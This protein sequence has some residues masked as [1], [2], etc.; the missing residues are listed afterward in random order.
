MKRALL[1]GIDHYTNFNDLAGC[2]NDV[3]A[4]AP[5]LSRSEDNSA[6]F[7]CQLRTTSL[8]GVTRDALLG[9][10]DALL[11]GGADLA[12]A[13]FAGHGSGSDTDVTLATEDGTTATPGIPLSEIMTKISVSPVKEIVLVLDCCFA[14]A[15]GGVPQLNVSAASLRGGVSI[16]AASRGDQ[17]AAETAA[18]R[19]LFSTYLSGA[20][21]GGAAD[22]LGRITVAGLYAYLDESFGAWDQRPVFKANVERLHELR[23]CR[24]AVPLQELRRLAELFPDPDHEYPLDPS[25]EPE[26]E[27]P[28]PEHEEVFKVLQKFRAAKLLEPVGEEHMYFAAIHSTGCRLTPL[29]RHYLHMATEGR[30]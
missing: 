7:D 6:N 12:L 30:F 8:G 2:E 18:G 23:T 1:V 20:L 28:D 16:L 14:G 29:G 24:P 3:S 13:Y 17:T 22:V 5:L 26:A 10:F 15:A 27:P 25:F 4:V 19:G 11:G 21:E 9:D